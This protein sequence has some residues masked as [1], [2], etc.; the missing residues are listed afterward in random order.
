MDIFSDSITALRS[1]ASVN[2]VIDG[3]PSLV[4]N[5]ISV[6]RVKMSTMISSYR[7]LYTLV[8]KCWSNL[9]EPPCSER[10]Y[11]FMWMI[12]S[13]GYAVNHNTIKWEGSSPN[14]FVHLWSIVDRMRPTLEGSGLSWIVDSRNCANYCG[15]TGMTGP[16]DVHMYPPEFVT[17]IEIIK[18]DEDTTPFTHENKRA[19]FCSFYDFTM[20]VMVPEVETVI[21]ASHIAALNDEIISRSRTGA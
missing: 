6:S 14:T 3:N 7:T 2:V 10:T 12:A 16:L 20:S 21:S 19:E 13:E 9:P 1:C 11:V 15:T 4:R 17:P 5:V 8:N 18:M